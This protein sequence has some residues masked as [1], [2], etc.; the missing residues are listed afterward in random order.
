MAEWYTELLHPELAQRLRIEAVVFHEKTENHEI[1]V[2]EHA[3]L[4]RVLTLDGVLQT[5]E[6]DEFVYHEMIA[7][8]PLLA[9][10]AAKRVLIVG[11]GDGGSLRRCLMH[12]VAK[13]T[14]VEI[15]RT[16]VECCRRHLPS[17]GAGAFD[18]ARAELVI[19]DGH[20]F[21]ADTIDRFDVIIVD[22]TDPNGPGEVL[23]SREF[24]ARCRRCLAPGGV[25]VSQNGMPFLQGDEL[26]DAA[27]RLSAVFAH[28]GFYIAAIPTY[29]GGYMAFGWATDGAD[30]RHQPV[31][32]IRERFAAAGLETRFYTPEIHVGA[33][34]LPPFIADLAP[35]G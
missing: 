3:Q 24:Y 15:D 29:Y 30:L 17:I 28:A 22:S 5:T 4:G 8:V 6:A 7:H 16:V 26:R 2:F 12:D 10:G 13:A 21:V 18:D 25:L 9:H 31:E 23:F 27:G 33:F 34:N 11:G 35:I 19:S 32:Q 20:A 14:V 1:M